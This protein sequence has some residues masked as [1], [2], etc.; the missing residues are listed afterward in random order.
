MN[1]IDYSYQYFDRADQ[2]SASAVFYKK[3]KILLGA[4]R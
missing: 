4:A 2:A 3:D 1:A